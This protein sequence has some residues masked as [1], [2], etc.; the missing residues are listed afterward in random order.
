MYNLERRQE[1]TSWRSYGGPSTEADATVEIGRIKEESQRLVEKA[2]FPIQM[3]PPARIRDEGT[4]RQIAGAEV[5]ER[6][7]IGRP[8]GPGHPRRHQGTL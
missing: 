5:G 7:L 2:E 3:L 4:A 8:D 1:K 6:G